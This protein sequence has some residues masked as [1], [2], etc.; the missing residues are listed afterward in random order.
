MF[1]SK[2]G[3]DYKPN[4]LR[5]GQ[6][7]VNKLNVHNMIRFSSVVIDPNGILINVNIT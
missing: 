2:I 5:Y 3:L 1:E 7:L 4:I 6:K